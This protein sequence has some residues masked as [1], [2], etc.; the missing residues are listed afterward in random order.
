M[1]ATIS[2]RT[3]HNHDKE[4]LGLSSQMVSKGIHPLAFF[5]F[6]SVPQACARVKEVDKWKQ[7]HR[8]FIKI[9][10]EVIVFA[11]SALIDM[12]GKHYLS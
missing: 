6:V 9:G 2:R 8:Y 10:F 11:S 1:N 12:H 7:V 4:A 5:S 3:Q